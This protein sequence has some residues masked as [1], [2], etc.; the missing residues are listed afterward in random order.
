M[1]ANGVLQLAAINTARTDY[2]TGTAKVLL[3][4]SSTNWVASDTVAPTTGASNTMV[5]SADVP[6]MYSATNVWKCTYVNNVAFQYRQPTPTGIAAGVTLTGSVYVWIPSGL[7]PLSRYHIT[8]ESQN[9]AFLGNIVP[10][11]MSNTGKWVRYTSTYTNTSGSSQTPFFFIIRGDKGNPAQ[12]GMAEHTVVAV[13]RTNA[14]GTDPLGGN[15]A[16]K[17][18]LDSTTNEHRLNGTSI[19]LQPNTTYTQSCYFKAGTAGTFGAMVTRPASA[20][21]PASWATINLATGAVNK[22]TGAGTFGA[23]DAGNGW[24][25]MWVTQ[26]TTATVT[27]YNASCGI[28]K[29]ATTYSWLGDGATNIFVFGYQL[30]V[31]STMQPFNNYPADVIYTTCWQIEPGVTAPTSY[32]PTSGTVQTR[33]A[34]NFHTAR[35]N[36]IDP[37]YNQLALA[38]A[39]MATDW[40]RTDT[41]LDIPLRDATY[42]AEKPYNTSVY[43]GTGGYNGPSSLSGVPVPIWRGVCNNIT[44]VL[45]DPTNRIYQVN[46]AGWTMYNIYEGGA[47]VFANGGDVTDLYTGTTAPGAVRTDQTHGYFQL[48]SVPVHQITLDGFGYFPSHGVIQSV[49]QIA[50]AMLVEDM[51]IPAANIDLTSFNTAATKYPYVAGI[52][53]G[54]GQTYSGVDALAAVLGGMAA[55]LSINRTGQLSMF[56]LRALPNTTLPKLALTPDNIVQITPK[57]LPNTLMPPP[58]RWRVGYQHN[59]TVQTSDLNTGSTTPDHKGFIAVTDRYASASSNTILNAYVRP[60]DHSPIGGGLANQSDAQTVANDMLA[61][62]TKDRKLFTVTVPVSIGIILDLGDVVSVRFPA[63]TSLI[64]GPLGVIVAETFN[65]GDATIVYDILI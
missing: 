24:W 63:I 22:T 56:V 33:A 37:P 2:S 25:R 44:P 54:D 28:A 38:F 7:N 3:E 64:N 65:G 40:T 8:C 14:A 16:V 49:P 58:Y 30:D 51:L 13:T 19:T 4:S 45:V 6:R 48:G 23:V 46:N 21:N 60:N 43:A 41:T 20:F 18:T 10:L 53:F 15:N 17:L 52:Y 62:W 27:I 47:A 5:S 34:D 39:G 50:K 31:G 29:D 35:Y 57:L 1:D 9:G 59:W 12:G 11:N 26:T 36:W 61:L 55:K 32:I 42:W